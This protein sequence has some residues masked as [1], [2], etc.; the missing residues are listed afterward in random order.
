MRRL[1]AVAVCCSLIAAPIVAQQPVI[2]ALGETIEISII[3][4]DVVVTDAKGNRVRG[5]TKDDFEIYEDGKLQPVTNFAEYVSAGDARIT[6]SERER[7]VE[8]APRQPRTV[9]IFLEE[10]RLPDFRVNPFFAAMKDVVG[11]TIES[12]DSLSIVT[13]TDHKPEVRIESSDDIEVISEVIDEIRKESIGV[14]PP[15]AA[16]VYRQ[17]KERREFEATSQ[18]MAVGRGVQAEAPDAETIATLEAKPFAIQARDEMRRRIKA[19]NAVIHRL[20]GVE[21][22]KVLLLATNRLGAYAGAEFFY[23]AGL[24]KVPA[25]E[26]DEFDNRDDVRTIIDNANDAGVTIYPFYPPGLD[27]EALGTELAM[28]RGTEVMAQTQGVNSGEGQTAA[29]T[30]TDPRGIDNL[31]MINENSMLTEVAEKTGG[32]MSWGTANIANLLPRIADDLTDYYSLAYRATTKKDGVPRRVTVKTKKRG[33]DVRARREVVEKSEHMRMQDRVNA[34]VLGDVAPPPFDIAAEV[35]ALKN[36]VLPLKV[37]VPIASLTLVP[38][39]EKF[40]GAFSVYVV[41][42]NVKGDVSDVTRQTQTFEIK[43][44]DLGKA[45]NAHFTYEVDMR[46]AENTTRVAVGVID[47]VSKSYGLVSVPVQ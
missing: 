46:V 3:N 39:D 30:V 18:E 17:A 21:G 14:A 35:T 37:R 4:V 27:M 38:T 40:T 5:L 11:K 23:A 22:R 20:A 15:S 25:M 31:I 24:D 36:G 6:S 29:G 41:S 33:Y 19:I 1:L 13:Y 12:G 28:R 26:H 7:E 32:M 34:A 42:A 10:F 16:L 44:A 47:E 8:A 43:E 45:D 2:P 9:V